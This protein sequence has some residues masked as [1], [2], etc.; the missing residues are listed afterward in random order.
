MNRY[1][2]KKQGGVVDSTENLPI[3]YDLYLPTPA[4]GEWPVVIFLHGF[5][6]F[7]DWG[8]FPDAC[9]E[10]AESGYAVL[11]VNFSRN[12]VGDNPTEFGR[13]DLFADNTLSQELRD[14]GSVIEALKNGEIQ[15]EHGVFDAFRV[16]LIGHSRG[17]H[18]ALVAA[19]EYEE[20]SAVVTWSAVANYNRHW[21]DEMIRDWEK[22]GYTEILN[23]RTGQ[24]MR[25]NRTLYDDALEN[26]DT[27]M[28]DVRVK[29]LY[30]PVCFIHGKEDESVPYQEVNSLYE[31][32]A[33]HDKKR[34]LVPE[35]GHT[36]GGSHP[37]TEDELPDPF[38]QVLDAT[39]RW[40][41]ANL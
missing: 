22:K 31:N 14:V 6:G 17:G 1:L 20:V 23:S 18:T 36:Y 16:G 3:R 27:L 9:F 7:K 24:L 13:L 8:P 33:S 4:D 2:I 10:I 11:A 12:G 25:L 38:R 40:F 28:A 26:A 39:I 41:D 34:I 5:K 15:S 35:T 32:C 29:E 19:S 21:T 37:F 30:I